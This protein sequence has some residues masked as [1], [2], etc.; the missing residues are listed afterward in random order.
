[1]TNV[2]STRNCPIC[3]SPITYASRDA[4]LLAIKRNS[5]CKNC[6][7]VGCKH[8][9]ETKKQLAEIKKGTKLSDI[10]KQ[11]I[12]DALRGDKSPWYGRKHSEE[13]K[14]KMSKW[15]TGK[16]LS[17]EHVEKIR[18]NNLGKHHT[19]E[20]KQRMSLYWKGRKFNPETLDNM[21][22]AALRRIRN[23]FGTTSYN[24]NACQFIN[25]L[26][27]RMGWELQHAENGGEIEICGYL[28]DGYDCHRN[29]VFEYDEKQHFTFHGELRNKDIIRQNRI[30]EF[31]K[32]EFYR[33]DSIR[34]VLYK[35]Q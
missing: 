6:R 35:I 34:K 12:G 31:L 33:Y 26:N 28:V 16:I 2:Y 9:N 17:L 18:K 10:T 32:C 11:K 4:F 13:S 25:E 24:K 19:P 7:R 21:R 15:H 22:R 29:I 27:K 23:Q 1:M 8:S 20:Y 30:L 14:Q 5:K 3:N